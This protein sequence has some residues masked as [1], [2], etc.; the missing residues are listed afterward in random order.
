MNKMN[1]SSQRMSFMRRDICVWIN[2]EYLEQDF[3]PRLKTSGS[4][5]G[6]P[7]AEMTELDF[8]ITC[9]THSLPTKETDSSTYYYLE[10]YRPVR[11]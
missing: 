3:S 5:K 1:L 10:I 7:A 4:S 8:S 2:C 6:M 9:N 11:I